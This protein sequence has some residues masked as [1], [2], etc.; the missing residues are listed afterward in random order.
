MRKNII[1]LLM[2]LVATVASL[3]IAEA[4]SKKA[5]PNKAPKYEYRL[6]AGF[7]IGGTSPLPLP[8]EIRKLNSYSPSLSLG[9]GADV[10]RHLGSK[11]AIM[12]GVTFENKGMRAEAQV[13]NYHIEMVIS[14]GGTDGFVEGA[15]TGD[16][17]TK[18]KNS[19]LTV[20]LVAVYKIS[21][22][23]ELNA[24]FFFS[25]LLDG[26]FHGEAR[27]GYIRAGD[28]TGDKI[29]VTTATYDFSRDVKKFN[30]G[31]QFGAR[32]RAYRQFSVYG[33][34]TWAF[35]DTFK[36]DFTG[37]SFKMYNIYF[38]VGFAYTF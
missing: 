20:P 19:Y 21:P 6:K 4:K 16:V 2:A 13:K 10:V 17:K 27:D 22:R 25:L 3:D 15:F 35:N 33:D 11:W 34:L 30:W 18:A 24:G 23:W 8:R 14:D 38:N 31:G 32:F 12:S 36:K 5:K 1:I 29:G 37:I 7:N 26:S 28:P 9:Q